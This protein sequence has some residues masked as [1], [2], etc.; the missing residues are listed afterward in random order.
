MST[1]QSNLPATST[2]VDSTFLP[3]DPCVSLLDPLASLCQRNVSLNDRVRSTTVGLNA[4]LVH[5]VDSVKHFMLLLEHLNCEVMLHVLY[6]WFHLISRR[7][8]YLRLN[9]FFFIFLPWY[10]IFMA[11]DMFA[12]NCAAGDI[13]SLSASCFQQHF[14]IH[15]NK[16]KAVLK[17]TERHLIELKKKR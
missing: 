12:L 5:G 10:G 13:H 9:R 17:H 11:L 3:D 15:R 16:K 6:S 4:V 1:L 8:I 14:I 2:L 7:N